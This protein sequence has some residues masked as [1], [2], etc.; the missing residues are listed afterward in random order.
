[1]G[2]SD[3]PK[4]DS[5]FYLW[6]KSAY[7]Y[8]TSPTNIQRWRLP[9]DVVTPDLEISYNDFITKYPVAIN[10]ET[11]TAAS[12]TAKD[13]SRKIF[14]PKFRKYLKAYVSYNPSVTDEDRRNMQLSIAD[15]TPT[16]IGP[17]VESP[18]I[19]INFS[20]RQKHSVIVKN[21]V[22][23]RS[24]PANAH[25][26]EVWQKIGGEKPA[27][28]EEFKYAG[29]STR[30]PFQIQYPLANVGQIVWYRVRWVNAKNEPGPWSEIVYAVIG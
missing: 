4:A 2:L 6:T 24:K 13:E 25:G 14:E 27:N 26:Y 30:S 1:M 21:L 29:F 15:T 19:E 5:K 11:R 17:P 16:T 20:N 8:A 7:P 9:L 18:T 22:G 28:D 3:I 23:K 12:V 10:P